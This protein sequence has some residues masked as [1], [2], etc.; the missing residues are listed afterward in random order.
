[1]AM[2]QE[3]ARFK[4]TELLALAVDGRVACVTAAEVYTK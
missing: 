4:S 1:M 2:L 3:V